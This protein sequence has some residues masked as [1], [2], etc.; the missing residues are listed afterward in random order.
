VKLLFD[1]CIGYG[2]Y[3]SI[4]G[5][6]NVLVPPVTHAHMLDFTGRQGE[7]DEVWVPRAAREGWLVITGDSGRRGTG[8]PLDVIMPM[9]GVTGIFLSGKL[10]SKPAAVKVNAVVSV[11]DRFRDVETGPRGLRY[12]LFMTQTGFALKPWP[13]SGPRKRDSP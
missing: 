11:L 1:E 8:A 7:P 10:Q 5:A 4:C 2:I 9:H 6:L 3:K 13:I 12:R